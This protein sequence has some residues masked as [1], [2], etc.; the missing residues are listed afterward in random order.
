MA[1]VRRRREALLLA[2]GQA[3]SFEVAHVFSSSEPK[4]ERTAALLSQQL[5]VAYTAYPELGENDRGGLPFL[6]QDQFGAKVKAFFNSLDAL[7][8]GQETA[9]QAEERFADKLESLLAN[10]EGNVVVAAHG[11]VNTL[12][13]ARYNELEL[14]SLWRSL[15]LPSY[16]VL[17]RPTLPGT[18]RYT[19]FQAKNHRRPGEVRPAF[20]S[21]ETSALV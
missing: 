6:P 1:A 21:C 19:I 5:G 7:I 18:G 3:A 4:A 2:S 10:V 20:F 16:L 17:G 13:T 14:F 8:I 9:R 11:T 12:F 15:Q